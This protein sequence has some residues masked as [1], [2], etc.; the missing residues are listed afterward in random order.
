[1]K[2]ILS[3]LIILNF[4]FFSCVSTNSKN[5]NSAAPSEAETPS[6][7]LSETA[8]VNENQTE[9]DREI[10]GGSETETGTESG[11]NT[12]NPETETEI[13]AETESEI[14]KNEEPG[15][16]NEPE[17][18]PEAVSTETESETATQNETDTPDI[19]SGGTGTETEVHIQA[20]DAEQNA[21]ENPLEEKIEQDELDAFGQAEEEKIPREELEQFPPEE[22][23]IAENEL[24]DD[25]EKLKNET[26][27]GGES[28]TAGG[29]PVQEKDGLPPDSEALEKIPDTLPE[30]L[31]PPE[32]HTEPKP[33]P[34]P[35]SKP[36]TSAN[37][38]HATEVPDSETIP[39]HTENSETP[40]EGIK[41]NADSAAESQEENAAEEIPQETDPEF[42]RSVSIK[43]GQYLDIAYPGTSWIYLGEYNR[44]NLLIFFSR[45][46]SDSETVFTLQARKPGTAIL[47]FYK[48]DVLSGEYI[49]D[50][51]QVQIEQP[52]AELEPA[53]G[54][55]V[56]APDYAVLIPQPPKKGISE[57]LPS[58]PEIS[59]FP[60]PQ[61]TPDKE[62]A[63]SSK[64]THDSK[65]GISG[66]Q[67]PPSKIQETS[68]LPEKEPETK[69]PETGEDTSQEQIQQ[70]ENPPVKI[71][72]PTLLDRAK[73]A[74]NNKQYEQALSLVNEFLE[75]PSDKTD[76]G[77]FLKAQILE[78]PSPVLNIKEAIAHYDK[79]TA[80]FPQ[81]KLW[82]SAK[83]R[84]VY[85]KRFYIDI[86]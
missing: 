81:S 20:P 72:D 36:D 59:D 63:D 80:D 66:Q 58:L 37:A 24:A 74:Y 55:H 14:Q 26:V 22:E 68:P 62:E 64:E 11:G 43:N 49:D 61:T 12:D 60:K 8:P 33:E 86:R 51:I 79:L 29:E 44:K 4:L 1:M 17:E 82:Q 13:E 10:S 7:E 19:N 77:L 53:D 54:T 57:E 78:A 50:Y 38:P 16:E 30:E 73:E 67:T 45:S 6:S 75:S 2:K 21:S 34:E 56:R 42:S 27:S 18:N 47:H 9:T 23:K 41:E 85:L 39:A 70:E 3:F 52:Q 83:N 40:K 35:E 46:V 25:F 28:E 15:S 32:E 69:T 48:N 5:E 76:E 31:P 84:S 65:E 71:P